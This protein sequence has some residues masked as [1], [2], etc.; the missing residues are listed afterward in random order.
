MKRLAAILAI[1]LLAA[2][3]EQTPM[4][5]TAPQPSTTP[6]AASGGTSAASPTTPANVGRAESAKDGANPQQQQVDPKERPQHRD[7]QMRGDKAGP[8]SAETQPKN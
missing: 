1:A 5:R 3:G 6:P 4:P 7:F 2:C 8:T